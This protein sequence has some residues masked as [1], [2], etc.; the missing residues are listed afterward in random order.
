MESFAPFFLFR[1]SNLESIL[2]HF[3]EKLLNDHDFHEIV[4]MSLE[5]FKKIVQ[6]VQYRHSDQS[7]YR[8]SSLI[9]QIRSHLLYYTP[10]ETADLVDQLSSFIQ[11]IL[12]DHEAIEF[13]DL[14]EN[15]VQEI[16]KAR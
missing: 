6:D 11:A 5:Y 7:V 12:E 9:Q 3:D 10:R 16:S 15:V 1:N 2:A 13:V 4:F 14:T 8:G